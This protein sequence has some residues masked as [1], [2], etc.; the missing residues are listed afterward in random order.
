[1]FA[2]KVS[3]SPSP[4]YRGYDTCLL[5]GT[6]CKTW[7]GSWLPCYWQKWATN[8]SKGYKAV[9][10]VMWIFVPFLSETW[11]EDKQWITWWQYPDSWKKILR[12]TAAFKNKRVFI[13]YL[14]DFLRPVCSLLKAG[15]V[16]HH[17]L[18][19]WN[20]CI[21]LNLCITPFNPLICLLLQVRG[22]RLLPGNS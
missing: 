12:T 21:L 5:K 1:M 20:Y 17:S 9:R 8:G 19:L 14:T 6:H 16:V 15:L 2:H 11:M 7:W 10:N 13:S 18:A 22:P 4:F 3:P